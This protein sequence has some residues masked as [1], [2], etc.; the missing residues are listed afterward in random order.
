[1]GLWTYGPTGHGAMGVW[2]NVCR[3]RKI[4]RKQVCREKTRLRSFRLR[5]FHLI[6]E[7]QSTPKRQ[8]RYVNVR[9]VYSGR[10]C[11]GWGVDTGGEKFDCGEI[12]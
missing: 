1:M 9:A 4:R 2:G 12:S 7:K 11:T 5:K 6:V 3:V 10:K 8:A